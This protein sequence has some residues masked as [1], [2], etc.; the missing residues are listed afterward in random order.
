[1]QYVA[2]A[3]ADQKISVTVY[4]KNQVTVFELVHNTLLNSGQYIDFKEW[5]YSVAVMLKEQSHLHGLD[6]KIAD[7]CHPLSIQFQTVVF[8]KL[9]IQVK[10]DVG[11][12]GWISILW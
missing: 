12:L 4:L 3:E 6:Y 7:S 5:K 8:A 9:T 10:V 2:C 11:Y 1:M